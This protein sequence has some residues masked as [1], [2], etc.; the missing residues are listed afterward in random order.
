MT[1]VDIDKCPS[2]NLAPVAIPEWH[3]KDQAISV[4][5]CLSCNASKVQND[6]ERLRH[7]T[8]CSGSLLWFFNITKMT[9]AFQ[10][11]WSADSYSFHT[12][13]SYSTR[14]QISIR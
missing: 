9:Q 12:D 11:F 1:G 13:M 6:G 8:K 3:R 10:M 7:K 14:L 4:Y 5:E 2:M